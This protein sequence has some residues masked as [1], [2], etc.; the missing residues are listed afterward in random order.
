MNRMCLIPLLACA[1]AFAASTAPMPVP[2]DLMRV[3]HLVQQNLLRLPEY[4]LFDDIRFSVKD[5]AVI[6]TGQ[7]SRPALKSVAENVVKRIEGVER[8]ENRIEVLPPSKFDEDIRFR[9]YAAIYSHPALSRY[10][11]NRGSPIF[12]SAAA[13]HLG[14]SFDPPIGYHPIHIIVQNQKLRLT[15]VVQNVGDRIIAGLIANG[16]AG[17]FEVQNDIAIADEMKPI[18]HTKPGRQ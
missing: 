17:V 14:L 6:L 10:N 2:A 1:P 3:V 5:G 7:A 16:I 18:R 8:V 13:A 11:P 4:S 9:A 15:G 12:I